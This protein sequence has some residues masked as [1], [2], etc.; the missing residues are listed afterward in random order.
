MFKEVSLGAPENA[1]GFVLWRIGARYQREV[2]RGLTL[3]NL[4][5]LQ[6]ITLALVAWFGREDQPVTQVELARSAGIH[7]M[8]VSQT[9]KALEAKKMV[10]RKTSKSDTRAKRV[11][12]TSS[13]LQAL[14]EAFP[15][16]I[17]V[18]NRLFGKAGLPGGI[19]LRELLR[20]DES[21]DKT[22][23]EEESRH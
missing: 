17:E 2:D 11:E 1:V 21:L 8:Q 18:Q 16:V 3:I 7:P 20:I 19:L 13:G 10:F 22:V 4:T 12:V 15:K 5:N 6:F 9:L 23:C 14:Q